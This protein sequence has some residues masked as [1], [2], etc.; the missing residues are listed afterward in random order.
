MHTYPSQGRAE[1]QESQL[2]CS[3]GTRTARV[4]RTRYIQSPTGEMTVPDQVFFG[5][6]TWAMRASTRSDAKMGHLK[7]PR[8][9]KLVGAERE[10]Q[11]RLQQQKS[12]HDLSTC[13]RRDVTRT[14]TGRALGWRLGYYWTRW[15]WLGETR[16]SDD[17]TDT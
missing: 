6:C 4:G 8:V 17:N 5:A 15:D 14:R 3:S 1:F 16:I 2:H 11:G 10:P 13:P 7:T 9:G 12:A